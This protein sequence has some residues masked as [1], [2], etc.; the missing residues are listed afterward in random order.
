[1]SKIVSPVYYRIYD[2]V[3]T[4]WFAV[5]PSGIFYNPTDTSASLTHI[6]EQYGLKESK[7]I[8]E[9]FRING[10]RPGYYLANL[11]DKKYYYCGSNCEDVKKKLLELGIG[12]A[13]PMEKQ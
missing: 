5:E 2:R 10:G 8:I 9:L 4:K 7:I 12:R 13:D 3:G 1:M 11:R 6:V